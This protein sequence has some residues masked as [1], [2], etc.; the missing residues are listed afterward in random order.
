MYG[1]KQAAYV[2]HRK[3]REVL[4]SLGFESTLFDSCLF[5]Q[6]VKP[7]G[8]EFTQYLVVIAVYVDNFNIIAEREED[9]VYYDFELAKAIDT[10]VED[11]NIILGVVLVETAHS[12]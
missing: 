1:L 6:F 11:P 7:G 5:F 4:T 2:F 3:V 10:R 8:C 12:I 9:V